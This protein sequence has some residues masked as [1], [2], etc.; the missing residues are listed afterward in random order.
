[1]KIVFATCVVL[2]AAC[3]PPLLHAADEALVPPPQNEGIPYTRS[4]QASAVAGLGEGIAVFPGSRYGWVNGLRVRLSDQDLLR[5]A[6][7]GHDGKILVPAS[8]LQLLSAKEL[9]A[10]APPSDLAPIADRWVFSVSE[11]L[12]KSNPIAS[13]KAAGNTDDEPYADFKEAAS[14]AGW[15][16]TRHPTG[17]TVASRKPWAAPEN[18]MVMESIVSLFDT[19]ESFANPDLATRHI[20]ILKRQGPWTDHVKVT[21]EQ[22]A[23]LDG[24]QTK[25]QWTPKDKYETE[26]IN[27]ALFGSKVPAPGIYPRLLLSPEDIPATSARVKSTELGRR[28]L[29]EMEILF[30]QSWWD[31]STSDGQIFEKLSSGQ[32]DGLEW[33]VPAGKPFFDA[34]HLFKGQKPGIYNSHIAYVPECLTAMGLYALVMQDD[35]LG[36]KVAAAV[37]NYY[38]LREPL[39]D[40]W[41]EISDSEF[42]SA[43][44]NPDGTL[45]PVNASGARTHWRNIHGLAAHMNLA[46][47][48]EFAGKWMTDDQKNVMRR[49]IAKSTYGRRSHGQDGPVRVRDVNWMAWDL[50]HFLAVAAIEGLP[51]FDREAYESGRESVRAFCEWGVDP[52][53]VIFES[54]GKNPGAFQFQFLSM[55]ILARRGDNLFAHPHWRSLLEGQVQMTSPNGRVIP[56]SGTQYVRHSRQRISLPLAIQ[57]KSVYPESRLPDYLATAALDDP[58]G[59]KDEA[60]RHLPIAGFDPQKYR[61]M[62]KSWKRLR[63]PSPSYPGFV[64]GV[65]FDSDLSPTT[66]KDLG[67]PLDFDAPVHGVFSAYSDRSPDAAWMNLMVRPNHYLGGGHHHADAG[68]FHFSALGVDWFTESPFT[69]HYTGNVHNLVLVDG[70]SQ[71]DGFIGV[72]ENV[73][74][75]YNAAGKYLGATQ[76]ADVSMASADL[77]YAYSWRW[78]T[79]PPQI[80]S[81]EIK[82][83]AWE[84]DPSPEIAKI[85]AGTARM[86][87]RPWWPNYNYSNYIA[88]S[89]APFNPM[90]YVFRTTGLVRGEHPYGFVIDDAKKDDA[91]RVY[92]W[93]AM[94]NGGVWQAHVEGLPAN[95]LALA[96]SGKDTDL[97][98]SAAKPPIAPAPGDPLLLVYALGMTSG[99]DGSRPLLRTETVEGPK[100]KKGEP[101]FMDRLAIT[102][103]ADQAAYR[104]LLLPARAGSAL[105]EVS[106]SADRRSASVRWGAQVDHFEF[107]TGSDARTTVQFRRG[108]PPPSR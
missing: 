104:I 8:F 39:L 42:G 57:L 97:S 21:P 10:P 88:T 92:E 99:G 84:M 66:R 45:I 9:A 75:G 34:A 15:T 72:V 50:T 58:L 94:L 11:L 48:L 101:Q 37:A 19:P 13:A 105:P 78:N 30:Q 59:E 70:K 65:L 62:V 46:L 51:G 53:G 17:V 33:E 7:V 38:K 61:E 93:T 16:V 81:K 26:G 68:M 85:F 23:A 22:L 74:N 4:A 95:A 36:Q 103:R 18:P 73:V 80:W 5:T 40:R 28:S 82:S 77:T 91:V 41:L 90:V 3:F 47:S 107:Q 52:M 102:Q 98:S 20:P 14:A 79:Q 71:A 96:A 2:A 35:A 63:L 43:I 64:R 24:P 56:N 108:T 29:I 32:L 31:P 12:P 83:L 6:A 106:C 54:N 89:R 86:K 55:M 49:F 25:W 1:M 27:T 67:L 76:A 100:N 87:W 69:Q 44:I 60:V